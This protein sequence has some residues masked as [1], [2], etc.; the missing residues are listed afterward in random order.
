[1]PTQSGPL[2]RSIS[3]TKN[4]SSSLSIITLVEGEAASASFPFETLV[5]ND[6][7]WNTITFADTVAPA[8]GSEWSRQPTNTV[9]F[10]QELDTNF[11]F[12]VPLTSIGFPQSLAIDIDYARSASDS[13]SFSEL[14]ENNY[15]FASAS[16]TIA[17]GQTSENN[18]VFETASSTIAFGQTSENNFIFETASS[19]ISFSD[20]AENNFLFETASST[21]AFAQTV[22][23]TLTYVRS[24]LHDIVFS[25]LV[26]EKGI[27][28]YANDTIGFISQADSAG[29]TYNVPVGDDVILDQQPKQTFTETPSSS[30]SFTQTAEREVP[31]DNTVTFSQTATYTVGNSATQSVTFDDTATVAGEFTGPAST[32]LTFSH[33]VIP[34]I[35]NKCDLH[36]YTP[37]GTLAA[38]PSLSVATSIS[39]T[40]SAFNITLRNPEFGNSD[41]VTSFRVFRQSRGGTYSSYR[42]SYWPTETT[43]SYSFRALTRTEAQNFLQFYKDSLGQE[44][45]LVDHEG[46][47][48]TGLIESVNAPVADNGGFVHNCGYSASLTFVGAPT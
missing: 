18:F 5:E 37:I 27:Q 20:L 16:N 24:V 39:L 32:T 21:V 9:E 38:A 36:E 3:T 4:N 47:S 25:D 15:I 33:T 19:T 35:E 8:A 14:A 41:D 1:M 17:F 31:A 22:A 46:R 48:W 7:A 42:A 43:L 13:I 45:T 23:A 40:Y 28:V 11:K 44:V 2:S 10:V 29:S 6:P 34:V 30:I 12:P 26:L